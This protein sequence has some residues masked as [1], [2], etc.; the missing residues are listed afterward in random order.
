M[1]TG[2]ALAMP[3]CVAASVSYESEPVTFGGGEMASST[4]T[5][6]S[7]LARVG[8]LCKVDGAVVPCADSRPSCESK[9]ELE[10]A[11]CFMGEGSG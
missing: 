1:A 11:L 9:W 7:T 3:P 8:S 4:E 2:E 10:S 6:E 5:S